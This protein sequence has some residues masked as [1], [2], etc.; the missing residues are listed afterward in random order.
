[1][2]LLLTIKNEEE[3]YSRIIEVVTKS[4]VWFLVLLFLCILLVQYFSE[5]VSL[6][7]FVVCVIAAVIPLQMSHTKSG[8]KWL[9]TLGVCSAV[10]ALT[11][12]FCMLPLNV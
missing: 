7:V 4:G 3:S 9:Y 8:R 1:M 12:F 10:T 2:N 6:I 11:C 5:I